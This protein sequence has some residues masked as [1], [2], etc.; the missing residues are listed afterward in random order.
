MPWFGGLRRLVTR[1]APVGSGRRP[2][3]PNRHG[4]AIDGIFAVFGRRCALATRAD[5]T[6]LPWSAG[7]KE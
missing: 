4:P 1:S 7:E 2:P 6:A 5:T 3:A